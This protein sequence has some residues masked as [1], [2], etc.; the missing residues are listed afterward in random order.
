MYNFKNDYNFIAH[1]NILEALLKYQDEPQNS[2][3]LD[4]HSE[5]AKKII[6]SYF[7]NVNADIHFIVGGTMV[8]K[9]VISHTL[10]PYEAVISADTGHIFVHE[11]GAIES[12]GHKV[13]TVPNHYG[14]IHISDIKKCIDSHVDEHMVLPKMV[15]ISE[16]T[17]YG[18]VYTKAEIECLYSFCKKNNLYLFIDG[19]RL[20][21]ALATGKITLCDI[22]NNCDA[23]YIGGAKNGALL[24]EALV[25][26]NDNLK[27]NMRYSIKQNGGMYSKGFVA[28]IQFEEL[29]RDNLYLE[30]AMTSNNC[31]KLLNDKLQELGVKMYE[32]CETNQVFPIFTNEVYKKLEE[33]SVFELWADLGD[34]KVVRFVCNFKS[35]E[36]EVLGFVSELEKIL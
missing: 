30:L 21:A 13:L 5:S 18:S 25:V 11:T 7:P 10:R 8:N 33:F 34:E 12:T 9:T 28:G 17:E 4:V 24:G 26:V 23:F 14:K 3:G 19:A 22:A 2:Y 16:T 29:F 32:K 15:Y 35:T 1:K 6:S 31:A 27:N 20:G 36:E